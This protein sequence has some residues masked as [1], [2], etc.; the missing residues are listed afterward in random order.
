MKAIYSLLF[1]RVK[2]STMMRL[3]CVTL[4]NNGYERLTRQGYG[5]SLLIFVSDLPDVIYM[6]LILQ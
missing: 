5:A 1:S 3:G 6:S 2:Q 4:D